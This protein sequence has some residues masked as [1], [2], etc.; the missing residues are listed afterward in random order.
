MT[1]NVIPLH[2]PVEPDPRDPDENEI[3]ER[4]AFDSLY[5][6]YL[7]VRARLKRPGLSD[8]QLDRLCNKECDLVWQ[9]IRTPAPLDYHLNY[10]FEVMREIMDKRFRDGRHR[11][12]LESIVNDIID[13]ENL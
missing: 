5:G 9:I 13:P 12:M 1:D 6:E 7:N 10:K 4:R 11:A 8:E 3:K 2:T